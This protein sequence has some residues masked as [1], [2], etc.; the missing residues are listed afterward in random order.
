MLLI[1][2]GL[3]TKTL[4]LSSKSTLQYTKLC[5]A[6]AGTLQIAF[7]HCQHLC[8]TQP[9]GGWKMDAARWE[10]TERNYSLL[11]VSSLLPIPV[12]VNHSFALF[13]KWQVFF[14]ESS[15]IL[16]AI[17]P[18]ITESASQWASQGHQHQPPY[19]F[20]LKCES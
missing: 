18:L 20:S 19:L 9:I 6:E 13:Q 7:L 14:P 16:F 15:W 2:K 17:F 5:D 8:C 3:C 10:K 12:S 4:S 11:F 1:L